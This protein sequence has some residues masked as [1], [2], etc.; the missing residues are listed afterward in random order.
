MEQ[1]INS[2]LIKMEKIHT[3]LILVSKGLSNG[4]VPEYT[5]SAMVDLKEIVKKYRD[6]IPYG[7]PQIVEA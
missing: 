6:R 7:H 4:Y 1:S 2:I 5:T 3:N